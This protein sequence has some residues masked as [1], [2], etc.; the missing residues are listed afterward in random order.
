[1]TAKQTLKGCLVS[2]L[3][4]TFSHF[5]QY[6]THFHTL[7]IYT[8]FKKLQKSYFKLLYQTSSK[9]SLKPSTPLYHGESKLDINLII[10]IFSIVQI[11]GGLISIFTYESIKFK[12]L[13]ELK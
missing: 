11:L 8:Y 1:M 6:Y 10:S 12:I 5:K 2:H 4:L 7:F 3:K 13:L 9:S